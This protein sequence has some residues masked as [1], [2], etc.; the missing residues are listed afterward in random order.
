MMVSKVAVV[1]LVAILAVPILL[2]Y[3]LNLSEETVTEYKPDGDS[4]NV[5]PL[6]QSGTAYTTAKADYYSL[7]SD[8]S[9]NHVPRM[10]VFESTSVNKTSTQFYQSS[11]YFYYSGQYFWIPFNTMT[12]DFYA[13]IGYG[14]N[15]TFVDLGDNG[16]TSY[17]SVSNVVAIYYYYEDN[18]LQWENENGTGFFYV[19][20]FNDSWAFFRSDA[21][22]LLYVYYWGN[23]TTQPDTYLDLAAGYRFVN[24]F[25]TTD[26]KLPQA[27]KSITM[28]VDLGSITDSSYYFT[29]SAGNMRLKLDKATINGV[30]NW[31]V[32]KQDPYGNYD[33]IIDNL[34]YDPNR[35]S[36]TYQIVLSQEYL[37]SYET[38]PIPILGIPSYTYYT[39]KM[40]VDCRYVGDW[41]TI[42]GKANSYQ[43]YH[44]DWQKDYQTIYST[45]DKLTLNGSK[46]PIIRLDEASYNA[47]AYNII[48]DETYTPADFRTNPTTTLSVQSAGYSLGFAGNTYLVDSSGN[49]TLGT[50][51]VSVNGLKLESTPTDGGYANKINGNT[52]S[53]TAQP[54]TIKFNGEWGA[55]VITV[56]NA[57][58]SYTH[59]E[60]TPGQFAWDGLDTNF[61]MVGLLASIGVFIA[62]GIAYRKTKAA[63]GALLVVCG[64]AILLFFTML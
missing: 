5:T 18:L 4:V 8:F 22:E 51:S 34:Y 23:F 27:T 57:Q 33:T 30:V 58:S 55:S 64:G 6:L 29:F 47:F 44:Y 38:E 50:H 35:S 39:I 25:G 1:A 2:G 63:L 32:C 21:N 13:F 56:A 54:S 14:H 48:T 24:N 41:P 37:G 17:H 59:T 60:W 42:I 49:I 53:V 15:I 9:Y 11:K 26:I 16:N 19:H 20:D 12:S 43:S 31:S 45:F 46:T 3:A 36:N 7:N 28:S 61:L 52:V 62:L 40:N 10:P